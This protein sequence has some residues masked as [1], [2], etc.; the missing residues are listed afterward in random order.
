M[1]ERWRAVA[2]A[3]GLVSPDGSTRPTIF[4]EMTALAQASGAA[5]LGQGFPDE[6]GPA[7]I[8]E[9]AIAAIRE[10]ANQYPPGRGIA[11]LR[12]AVAAHQRRHYG[13]ELDPAT[14]ILITAGATEALTAAVLALAG[15]GDEVVTLEPFYDSHAAA[16]A[17]AGA[18]HV[19]VPLAPD[20]TGGFRVDLDTLDAAV[21]PRTR[22][23][24]V[25]SPHNPTGAV[26]RAEELARIAA[27]AQ[28]ADAVVITDEVYEHLVFDDAVHIP[29]ASLPG[30]AERTLT[31]SSA[32]KTFSLTGWKVGWV[33]G[34]AGLIEAVLAV[35]QF[36]TY[37]GGAPFQPAIARALSEGDADV[38][39]LRDSLAARRDR[40][41]TGLRAA[42]FSVVVPQGTYF[43]CA[44]ATPFLTPDTPDGAAFARALPGR[45]GVACVPLSAFC[46]EGSATARA[47]APWVRFT[48]V[49]DA[50]TLDAAIDRLGA[51]RG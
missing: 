3:T 26:L 47:L 34:P 15:P 33:S 42:G 13:I 20:P 30:M 5:N 48:F 49:K 1:K 2:R 7:W 43:V 21:G 46:R 23:I 17:L 41:V 27:A 50:A 6:D 28:R 22:A 31:V 45:A 29:I 25:N 40:L 51:L 44:D 14:E 12:E 9:A 10:G 35:K 4:A 39:G 37:S 11:E 19:A 38:A 24:L 36:L 8:R 16:I 32:G 18:T